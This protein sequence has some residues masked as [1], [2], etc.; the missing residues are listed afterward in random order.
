MTRNVL[1]ARYHKCL[2]YEAEGRPHTLSRY[3]IV[4]ITF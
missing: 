3:A 1:H 4:D 2:P